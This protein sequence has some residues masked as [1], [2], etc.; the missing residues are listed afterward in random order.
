VHRLRFEICDG[1]DND[2]D[3][4][5][6][7]ET[8]ALPWYPDADGDGFG[9]PLGTTTE[10]CAPLAGHSLLPIDCDDDDALRGPAQP[11]RCNARDDN[12]DGL[13]NFRV[14]LGDTE[15]DDLDGFADASCGGD[16][17][18]DRD[19]FS[20]PGAWEHCDGIDNDCDGVVDETPTGPRPDYFDDGDGD[21]IGGAPVIVTGCERPPGSIVLRGGDCA[22]DNAARGPN[23]VEVCNGVDDDCDGR[24]DEGAQR[25]R[26]YPDADRDGF[27]TGP[28][29]PVC[30][31][32]DD[33][34][35]AGGD[36]DD[37][38]P[39]A[40]PTATEL[41]NG[42]DD[43]CDGDIDED[44]VAVAWYPDLDLDGYGDSG[45]TSV[46]SCTVVAGRA[47]NALDC[48]DG[49]R[50]RH[51]G[52]GEACD[53]VDQDC[54]SRIDEG[55][56][57][58]A[59]VGPGYTGACGVGGACTCVAGLG[60]CNMEAADGCESNAQ[61]DPEH[62]GGCGNPCGIGDGCTGTQCDESPILWIGTGA[63]STCLGRQNGAVACA[64]SD[65]E[66]AFLSPDAGEVH[67]APVLLPIDV[68]YFTVNG[69]YGYGGSSQENRCYITAAGA[70]IRC[71]GS[72][73][74]GELGDGNGSAPPSGTA[75]LVSTPAGA[76][77]SKVALGREF[78][79][80]LRTT[81]EVDCWG[82]GADGRLGTGNTT[83]AP[84]PVAAQDSNGPLSGI[85]DID[86]GINTACAVRQD[87]TVTCWGRGSNRSVGDV[88]G[89][90]VAH[91]A[92]DLIDVAN[93]VQVSVGDDHACARLSDGRIS[94]WGDDDFGQLGDGSATPDRNSAGFVT[95]VTDAIDV[96]VGYWTSCAVLQDHRVLCWGIDD[97]GQVG[98]GLPLV[99]AGIATPQVVVDAAGDPIRATTVDAGLRRAG[100]AALV[101]GGVACWGHEQAQEFGDGPSL[102]VRASAVRML[103]LP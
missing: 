21:G 36:C 48:D 45:G 103:A 41:C 76:T 56:S 101:D 90:R 79:C 29:V 93:A 68:E 47:P 12:C 9:D 18:D 87:G 99:P 15:D 19:P 72:Y 10:S 7:E 84:T 71:W 78:M 49:D 50:L 28:G 37:A 17:C 67:D 14:A 94:C 27:G 77:Y 43:D 2:C 73:T 8:L 22:D 83:N 5:I 98:D 58:A 53:G 20:W 61:N 52:A 26:A 100:C 86:A 33:E 46:T 6:D 81:G 92:N 95:L 30:A 63:F 102:G 40:H 88:G 80:G 16:D 85:I 91:L 42:G 13:A 3:G 35:G 96:S 54:D 11:E 75:A 60:D 51:P 39:F 59:C 38:S 1:V 44:A 34:A 4:G 64:G 89:P 65:F 82:N 70:E 74:D 69:Y 55:V 32:E 57:V 25:L 31:L 62:C 24:V 97:W 66:D 23:A